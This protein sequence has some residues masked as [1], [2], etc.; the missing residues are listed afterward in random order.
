M[1]ALILHVN[2]FKTNITEESTL[3]QGIIPEKRD[4]LLEEIDEGLVIF[5]CVEKSDKNKQL[6]E[7][8][9]EIIKS[10]HE[11]GAKNLMIAP[12]VHLSKQ[13]ADPE[14]AKDFYETIIK[15][16]ENDDFIVKSSHFGYHKSLLLDIKG[17]PGSFRYREFY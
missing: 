5:F 8:Y 7:L 3:P 12:F 6:E 11:V 17:H 15:K 2:K 14:M 16:F 1:R 10:A 9:E 4:S 13:I